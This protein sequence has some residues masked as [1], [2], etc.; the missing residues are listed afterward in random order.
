M[1][2]SW[3]NVI[4]QLQNCSFSGERPALEALVY[5]VVSNFELALLYL[6][7]SDARE[8]VALQDFP[9]EDLVFSGLRCL[10]DEELRMFAKSPASLIA[11]SELM[12]EESAI[13]EVFSRWEPRFPRS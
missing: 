8:K 6:E 10:S 13:G 9:F 11:L 5:Q 12:N 2:I 4:G 1:D 7:T 3:K